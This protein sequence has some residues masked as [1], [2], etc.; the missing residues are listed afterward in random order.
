M[1]GD[2]FRRIVKGSIKS[3]IKGTIAAARTGS[4]EFLLK[5]T[6]YGLIRVEYAVIQKI[7]ERTVANLRGVSNTEV[8]VEKTASTVT[9]I[10]IL[11][12]LTLAEGY[13]A[14][15]ASE[16]ADKAINETLKSLLEL[17][18]YVPVEVQVKRIEQV[19]TK[20]RRVR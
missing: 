2:F 4:G 10:K 5:K 11:L 15:R 18:F 12:T 6:D 8:T 16:A 13:S 20:K 1:F 14:P 9:P 17:E 3:T 19:V 7:V